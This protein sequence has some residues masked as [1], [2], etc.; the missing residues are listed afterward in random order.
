MELRV[1][2]LTRKYRKQ[3]ALQDVS[4]IM[5][6]GIYGLLGKNGAGKSTLMRIL[7]TIDFPTDGKVFYNGKDIFRSGEAYRSI[8]GYMP[9]D[10]SIYSG[11]NAVDFLEYMGALKGMKRSELKRKIPEVLELVHLSDVSRKKIRTYSGGMKRRIGI[12][13]AIMNNPDILILDEPTAGLDPNERLS[14][15]NFISDLAR[16]K[17]VLLST[18]IVSDIEVVANELIVMRKGEV[19]ETGKI[20]ELLGGI[21]E[22][23][24]ETLLSPDEYNQIRNKRQVVHVRQCE[25]K[26]AV[27]YIGEEYQAGENR[28]QEPTLE[29][30]YA[31]ISGKRQNEI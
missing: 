21:R 15:S 14:F 1:E 31:A 7:A 10:Y 22:K 16:E 9:Q 20:E 23:V 17:I 5:H 11:F 6:E 25:G 18:H 29:D 3:K 28:E 13:Q 19:L 8:L 30:Y 4:F 26:M 12:A 2:G 24:W 27:R